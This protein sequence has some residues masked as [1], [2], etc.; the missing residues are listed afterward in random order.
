MTSV[1]VRGK[2]WAQTQT[3]TEGRYCEDTQEKR[4]AETEA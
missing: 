2:I 3:C 4:D 1:L